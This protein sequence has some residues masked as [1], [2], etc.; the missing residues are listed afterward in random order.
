MHSFRL[1]Y[2]WT[3]QDLDES[4]IEKV[5]SGG[6]TTP[7]EYDANRIYERRSLAVGPSWRYYRENGMELGAGFVVTNNRDRSTLMYPF[8]DNDESTVADFEA[9][10]VLPLGRFQLRAGV[11]FGC[12]IGE[13]SHVIDNDNE[14]LGVTTFPFRLQ[15]WWDR[16]QE[17]SDA[18]RLGGSLALRYGF[19]L[20]GV[21]GLFLEA[22]CAFVHA[23]DIK[24]L[25]GANR[26]ETLLTLGYDF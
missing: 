16:E 17:L 15:E 26:Q 2:D 18:T 4:V 25:P 5:S 23:F 12:K 1:G 6:V 10:A 22:S 24:L 14:G 13:H 19:S 20:A 8:L 9:D 7:V 21:E 3:R 11:L